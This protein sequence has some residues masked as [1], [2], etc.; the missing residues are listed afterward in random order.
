MAALNAFYDFASFALL[1]WRPCRTI[2]VVV[3]QKRRLRM[4]VRCRKAV[5]REQAAAESQMKMRVS[6]PHRRK[7]ALALGYAPLLQTQTVVLAGQE[8]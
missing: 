7:A 1:H 2:Y 4:A 3:A 5:A 8:Q 6:M